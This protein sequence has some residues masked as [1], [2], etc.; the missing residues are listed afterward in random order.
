MPTRSPRGAASPEARAQVSGLVLL[1]ASA[2]CT[3][4]YLLFLV[5]PIIVK[6]VLPSLGG[7]PM[8][9]NTSVLFF[10]LMLL[11]GYA[12]AHCASHWLS[13]RSRTAIYVALLLLPFVVLPFAV[14]VRA[15]P[16]LGGRNPVGWLLTVLLGSIGAPFFVLASSTS[17]IQKLFAD[18][19]D[20]SGRDP[21]FLYIAGNA[22]S[23]LALLSYP[24][25]VEPMLSLH[26]Q[27]RLWTIGYGMFVALALLCVSFAARTVRK[28]NPPFDREIAAGEPIARSPGRRAR[29]VALAAIPSS[30]MLGV[31][32]YLT[33]DLASVPLLWIV[34]LA[35]YL[36]TFILAF[37][38]PDHWRR[39]ADRRLPICLVVVSVALL[40][41]AGGPLWLVVPLHLVTFV[42]AGLLCHGW[43]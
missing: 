2:L 8:V 24:V 21:Y 40:I 12:Y 4:S 39:V 10:Q 41:H 30:L 22:G 34:P 37:A 43:V 42:V 11:A 7:G 38:R 3:S 19:D 16:P 29:W 15:G 25:L 28:P 26:D 17:T 5:E 6:M 27:S 18:T 33:S 31:T 35:L 32:G 20:P 36:M 9:W 14:P 23:L 13:T 1:F